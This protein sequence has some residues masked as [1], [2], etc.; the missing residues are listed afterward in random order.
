[1]KWLTSTIADLIY[2]SVNVGA[3]VDQSYASQT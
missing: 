1:M 2:D 3:I